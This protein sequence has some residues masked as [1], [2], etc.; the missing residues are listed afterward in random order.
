M[1]RILAVLMA[2]CL[3][4][5]GMAVA[6]S[7][8]AAGTWH[9]DRLATDTMT[10]NAADVGMSI[11]LVLN[12]DGTGE[13]Q[14][15]Y[16]GDNTS[17]ALTWSQSG[18][19]V[20]ISAVGSTTAELVD[21]E[22]V[23]QFEDSEGKMIMTRDTPAPSADNALPNPIVA[24][25]EDQFFGSWKGDVIVVSGMTLSMSDMNM[26]VSLEVSA[27]KVNLSYDGE[28][29]PAFT[30]FSNGTLTVIGANTV[31]QLCD[32]GRVMLNATSSSGIDG[33][34]YMSRV[35]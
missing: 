35:D 33:A 20:T 10:I 14:G 28:S 12:E 31:I 11:T 26:N 2:L 8:S 13:V 3:L 18:N 30:S 6:E 9:L 22:L 7:E 21:G 5:A 1:K 4:C 15:D 19:T 16:A 24:E 32:D 23:W 17:S 25:S 34:I 29:A 27:G